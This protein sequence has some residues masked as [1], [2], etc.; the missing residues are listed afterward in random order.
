VAAEWAHERTRLKKFAGHR[1]V[2]NTRTR[3]AARHDAVA[4]PERSAAFRFCLQT[5]VVAWS[6]PH[7]VSLHEHSPDHLLLPLWK[8]NNIRDR[9]HPLHKLPEF[10]NNL[11]EQ[12]FTFQAPYLHTLVLFLLTC[13]VVFCYYYGCIDMCLTRLINI[14]Q[15]HNLLYFIPRA[16][17][18]Y[19]FLFLT[20]GIK[21]PDGL[22]RIPRGL[23]KIRRKLPEWP[24]LRAVLKHKGIV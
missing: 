7:A 12:S 19:Y 16:G 17:N 24:L 3:N 22:A 15:L 20:L 2:Y 4:E 8:C 1:P 23:E 11:H 5:S 9:C 18:Y 13:A 6:L 21:D 14:A 10:S